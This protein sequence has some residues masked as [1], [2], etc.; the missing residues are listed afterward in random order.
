MK[1]ILLFMML[2]LTVGLATGCIKLP[3]VCDGVSPDDSRLCKIANDTGVR[4]EAVGNILIVANM[5]A[6]E[7]GAYPKD[8]AK[9]VFL[10]SLELLDSES[11]YLTMSKL[12]QEKVKKYPGLFIVADSYLSAMDIPDLITDFDR[13]LLQNWLMNQIR[14]LD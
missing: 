1:K 12:I 11:T 8:A 3:S 6:I 14:L 5:A 9:L 13:K 10:S 4:I 7:S 2:V